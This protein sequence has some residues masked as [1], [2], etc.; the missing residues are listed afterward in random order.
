MFD[1][2]TKEQREQNAKVN[3]F[4]ERIYRTSKA[5]KNNAA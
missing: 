3:E 2:L 4:C 5:S 1:V